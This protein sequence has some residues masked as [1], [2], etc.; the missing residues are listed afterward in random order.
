MKELRIGVIGAGT[1]GTAHVKTLSGMNQCRITAICDSDDEK[2]KALKKEKRIDGTTRCFSDYR[3]LISSG[4]CDCVVVAT[5]HPLHSKIVLA[6]FDAKLHVMCEKPI[7]IKV[8]EAEEMIRAWKKSNMRFCTMYSM[9]THPVNRVIK[10]WISG[11]K[12]GKLR[13]VEMTCTEWLRTQ[14]YYDSQSWRGSWKG[15]GGGLLM[16]QAPH[17][18]DLLSWWFGTACEISGWVS[19]RFHEIETEDEV[20]A[21]VWMEGGFPIT[22]Y[23]STGEAPGKDYLEIVGDAGT[24]VKHNGKLIFRKLEESLE[25][26][27]KSGR[28]IFQVAKAED[29]EIGI[30]DLPRG[31]KAV[32]ENF[33]DVILNNL[34]DSSLISPGADGINA[35]EWANAILLSAYSS[36]SIKLPHEPGEY[37]KLLKKLATGKLKL[38]GRHF[39]ARPDER[40]TSRKGFL[41]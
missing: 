10:D 12:L 28:E 3:K 2:L 25:K 32:F 5:P 1:M 16:N 31:H 7:G 26:T 6:A 13:R 18:L 20:F 34:P 11:G 21:L 8:S 38:D 30:P 40:N 4:L 37:E 33:F 24:L 39:I 35:L 23:A 29:I 15:E 19:N 41:Q 14:K 22:F 9:R 17:N 36:G 27:I